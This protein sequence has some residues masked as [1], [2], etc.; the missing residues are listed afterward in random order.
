VQQWFRDSQTKPASEE[1]A[2]PIGAGEI[3][4]GMDRLAVLRGGTHL[5]NGGV[6]RQGG[7]ALRPPHDRPRLGPPGRRQRLLRPARFGSAHSLAVRV[8]VKPGGT[9]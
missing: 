5:G 8:R 2:K 7:S 3:S 1:F 4:R 6:P 9:W